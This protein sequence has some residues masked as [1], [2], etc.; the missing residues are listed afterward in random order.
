[1]TSVR[2]LGFVDLKPDVTEADF[3]AAFDLFS[4]GLVER[5]L[6]IGWV[7]TRRHP[8]QGYDSAPPA[9]KWLL[10]TLFRDKSQAEA[11]WDFIEARDADFAPLHHNINRQVTNATFALYDD[12]PVGEAVE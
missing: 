2:M 8:H 5:D 11:C 12:V 6:A 3:R 1:M 7:L 9:Q 10:S 4:A